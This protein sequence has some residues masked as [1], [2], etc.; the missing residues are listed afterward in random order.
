VPKTISNLEF[1]R[2]FGEVLDQVR[3]TRRPI[4]ITQHGVPWVMLRHPRD[5]DTTVPDCEPALNVRLKLSA[6]LNSVHYQGKPLL[7]TRRSAAVACLCP[8]ESEP[9]P[10]RS[11]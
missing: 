8:V 5:L 7:I 6:H 11:P 1:R 3:K 4:C 2:S 10:T 9:E